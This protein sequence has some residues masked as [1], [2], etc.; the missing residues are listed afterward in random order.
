MPIVGSIQSI[1]AATVYAGRSFAGW[2]DG[3][4]SA[5][6]TFPVGKDSSVFTATYENLQPRVKV[7]LATMLHNRKRRSAFFDASGSSDPEAEALRFV[8]RFS[9]GTR[10]NTPTIRKSFKREGTYRVI[11]TVSDALGAQ[12]TVS[13]KVLV[14][15]RRGVRFVR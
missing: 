3:I 6:R 1:R 9:D 2:R 11:L 5:V 8:W 7:S 10:Y 12:S 13:R 14:S 15:T 4:R